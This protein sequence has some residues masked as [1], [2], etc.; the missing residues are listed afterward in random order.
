[1]TDW[2]IAIANI[3]TAFT[4][5]VIWLQFKAS[6]KRSRREKALE[7]MRMF[8]ELLTQTSHV[9][10]RFA[11]TLF[12]NLDENQC[13]SLWALENFKIDSK[14]ESLVKLCVSKHIESYSLKEI[15]GQV[16]LTK[17]Y[18]AVLRSFAAFHLNVLEIIFAAWRH[19]IADRNI[20]ENEFG[21]LISP[22]KDVFLWE[23]LRITSGKFPSIAEYEATLRAKYAKLN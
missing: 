10:S 19:N 8:S 3:I 2:I 7:M 14:H 11:F 17:E 4:L 13:K 22:S 16:E 18:V 12:E 20:I 23:K 15:N 9:S 1:M 5:F 6:H 21:A